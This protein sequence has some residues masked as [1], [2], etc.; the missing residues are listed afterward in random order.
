MRWFLIVLVLGIGALAYF[1][2]L[3]VGYVSLTPTVM[4]N[5]T[6]VNNYTYRTVEVSSR[7][8]LNGRCETRSGQVTLRLLSPTNRQVASALCSAGTSFGLNLQGG[9][10]IGFYRLTVEFDRF[11]GLIELVENRGGVVP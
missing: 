8:I 9:G 7:L 11:T 6:G 5:A 3:R 10:E 2:G 1:F 4:Y